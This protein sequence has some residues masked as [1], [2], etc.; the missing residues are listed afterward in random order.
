MAVTTH[1]HRCNIRD[2]ASW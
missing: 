1:F 2:R